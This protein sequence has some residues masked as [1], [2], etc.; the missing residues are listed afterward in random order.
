MTEEEVDMSDDSQHSEQQSETTTATTTGVKWGDPIN[1][2][3]QAELQ[4]YLDR[5]QEETDHGERRGPFEK[6]PGQR[7]VHLTGADVFWLAEQRK[8][9]E[10]GY[11]PNLHLEGAYL[12]EAQLKDANLR[13]TDLE[14][15]DL[16]RT[17]MEG[18]DLRGAWFDSKD[19]TQSRHTRPYDQ[20][21]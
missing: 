1:P 9:G 2:E 20:P 3:R 18:A 8:H 7:G 21:R 15:A 19:Y 5:W 13:R 12:F 6:G 16:G 17:H 4:G 10:W 14:G 11:V